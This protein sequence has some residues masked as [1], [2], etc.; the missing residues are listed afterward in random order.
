MIIDLNISFYYNSCSFAQYSSQATASSSSK[1]K[2]KEVLNVLDEPIP[3]D[4]NLPD[5]DNE[6]KKRLE[7][8]KKPNEPVNDLASNRDIGERLANLKDMPY[9]EHDHT[10][11]I[12]AVDKRT[13]QEKTNDLVE[14]FMN[15]ASIDGAMA[16]R[17]EDDIDDIHRRLAALKGSNFP[18][19]DRKLSTD[20]N[21][22]VED[23]ET[24]VKKIVTK[25]SNPLIH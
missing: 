3:A 8:L 12:N 20:N 22:E 5:V 15:E 24:F 19:T 7:V 11:L 10:K 14:Q 13:E 6:I 4:Q 21:D 16:K 18:P 25:V 1:S 23:E 2:K 17:Q 9:K